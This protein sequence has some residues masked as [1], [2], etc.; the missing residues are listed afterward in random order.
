MNLEKWINKPLWVILLF[1][2]DA[3]RV[4]TFLPPDHIDHTT[5]IPMGVGVMAGQIKSGRCPVTITIL[6]PWFDTTQEAIKRVDHEIRDKIEA[7]FGV[8]LEDR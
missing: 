1:A 4:I 3:R 7:T 6:G 2:P 8:S 5:S